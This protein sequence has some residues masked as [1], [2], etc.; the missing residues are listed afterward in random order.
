MPAI[1]LPRISDASGRW[2]LDLLTLLPDADSLKALAERSRESYRDATPFAHAQFD[3][4]LPR[5]VAEAVL[6]SFPTP[7]ED[8]WHRTDIHHEK[9]LSSSVEPA[10]PPA[11]RNVLYAFNSATFLRFLE[12]LTGVEGLI[13]DPYFEGGG[14]HQIEP[15]GKLGVHVDFNRYPRFKIDRRLNLLLYLNQDWKDEYGGHLELWDS[16]GKQC[17]RK[18]LPVFNR[19]VV[20]STTETSYHGHPH[21]LTCPEGR[22]RKSIALYYY[23]NGRPRKGGGFVHGTEFLPLPGT[24]ARARGGWEMG[25]RLARDL[26]PPLLYRGLKRVVGILGVRGE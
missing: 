8:I 10:I 12:K 25:K 21:P 7:R 18:I 15:G 19:C 1:P 16:S 9:K 3:D 6:A 5:D 4:F 11:I 17:R 23:T 24:S 2:D 14:L 20:F 13:P 22:T 26:M